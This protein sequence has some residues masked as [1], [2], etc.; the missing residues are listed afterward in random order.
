S[1][2]AVAEAI[3]DTSK[4]AVN[5]SG[6]G[7]K[8][9]IPKDILAGSAGMVSVSAQK[10][11]DTAKAALPASVKERIAGKTVYS[12]DLSDANG[13]ISFT[14]KKIT[15]SLPYVLADGENADNVKVYCISGENLEEFD[16]TYDSARKVAVFETEHF[17]DWFVDVLP[18]DSSSKGGL[19]IGV[20]I[21][22][23]AAVIVV[24]AVAAVFVM[25]KKA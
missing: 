7:W 20:I 2:A 16:A 24:A 12:L 6:D 22:I 14:G 25:K 18:D 10:M 4:T 5:V 21:G 19:S 1:S 17:S 23:V 13:K 3:N 15:V 8:M 9:E 11:D